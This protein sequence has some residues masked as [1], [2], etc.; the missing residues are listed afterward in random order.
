MVLRASAISVCLLSVSEAWVTHSHSRRSSTARQFG[1]SGAQDDLYS[2]LAPEILG[3]PQWLENLSRTHRSGYYP[4]SWSST[5]KPEKVPSSSSQQYSTNQYYNEPGSML[6]RKSALSSPSPG[7]PSWSSPSSNLSPKPALSSFSP[8]PSNSNVMHPDV[9]TKIRIPYYPTSSGESLPPSTSPPEAIMPSFTPQLQPPTLPKEPDTPVLEVDSLPIVSTTSIT[10]IPDIP[11]PY[12]EHQ[13]MSFLDAGQHILHGN[14]AEFAEEKS[15]RN[16]Q[17]EQAKKELF[18]QQETFSTINDSGSAT[19]SEDT[20]KNK[21][22]II[23]NEVI[24]ID[25]ELNASMRDGETE[26]KNEGALEN[27]PLSDKKS[28]I[29]GELARWEEAAKRDALRRAKKGDFFVHRPDDEGV[30]LNGLEW[31]DETPSDGEKLE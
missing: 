4:A 21:N 11:L 31:S 12:P 10:T 25:S 16:L 28:F 17:V 19:T 5:L 20:A 6:S 22:E 18:Q 30:D 13:M 26:V 9:S 24:E 3:S 2:D 14:I 1:A 27:E 29:D 7:R 23:E 8:V 15:Q